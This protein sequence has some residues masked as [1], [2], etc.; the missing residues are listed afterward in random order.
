MDTH[1]NEHHSTHLA[2]NNTVS[3]ENGTAAKH[4]KDNFREKVNATAAPITNVE[5]DWKITLNG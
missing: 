4:T 3:N 5:I 2:S 1:L